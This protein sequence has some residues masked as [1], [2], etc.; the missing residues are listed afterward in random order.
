MLFIKRQDRGTNSTFSGSALPRSLELVYVVIRKMS[1][2]CGC[3]LV[4]LPRDS[5]L[6]QIEGKSLGTE[7]W[8]LSS[9]NL[10]CAVGHNTYPCG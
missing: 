2:H 8:R 9:L 6:F 5:S 3:Y 7:V 10:Y 1:Y 4:S